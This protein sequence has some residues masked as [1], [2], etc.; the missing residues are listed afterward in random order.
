[1]LVSTVAAMWDVTPDFHGLAAGMPCDEQLLPALGQMSW[2][3]TCL[4]TDLH[5]ALEDLRGAE[6]QPSRNLSLVGAVHELESVAEGTELAEW[7]R[8]VG[9]NAV[10]AHEAVVHEI[11]HGTPLDDMSGVA[12]P[13]Q[14]PSYGH[15]EVVEVTGRLINAAN[16]LPTEAARSRVTK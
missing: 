10:S 8:L 3:A 9:A 1:M 12:R 15:N 16:T 5:T 7:C 14:R 4:Y 2:A 13:P 6:S 11:V